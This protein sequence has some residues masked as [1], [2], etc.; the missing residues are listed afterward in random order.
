MSKARSPSDIRY[1]YDP[2][3][4]LPH[5][6]GHDVDETEVEAVLRH[7]IENR[8]GTGNSRVIIGRTGAGRLLKVIFVEDDQGPG[9]FVVTAYDVAGKALT[10]FRRRMRKRGRR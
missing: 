9:I 1:H 2:D 3:T 4:G 10:A 5:I 8:P 6:H 7:P